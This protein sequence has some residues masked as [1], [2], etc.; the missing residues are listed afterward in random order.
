[1]WVRRLTAVFGLTVSMKVLRWLNYAWSRVAEL[2]V[3]EYFDI[4]VL[5]DDQP[6]SNLRMKLRSAYSRSMQIFACPSSRCKAGNSTKS[7]VVMAL[8]RM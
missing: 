8:I 1:M 5:E 6:Y 4:V 3:R 2:S 7:M